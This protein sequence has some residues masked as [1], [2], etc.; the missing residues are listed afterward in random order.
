MAIAIALY[1]LFDAIM[2]ENYLKISSRLCKCNDW[3][4]LI[5][6][7]SQSSLTDNLWP[8]ITGGSCKFSFF[9]AFSAYHL[10]LLCG[11]P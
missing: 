7:G 11:V 1:T 6:Y 4:Y 10:R 3:F 2:H 9:K 8:I 5:F